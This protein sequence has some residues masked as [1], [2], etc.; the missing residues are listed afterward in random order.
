MFLLQA[1]RQ[2]SGRAKNMES[3]YAHPA[4]AAALEEFGQPRELIDSGGWI[5]ERGI[6]G[7]SACDAMGC[8]PLFAC[9]DW[10]SLQHDLNSIGQD[11]VSLVI[12]TDPFGA[13]S[14]G[15]LR[16][17]FRDWVVPFKEHFVVDLSRPLSD[18][19]CSHHRRNAEKA[20]R[21]VYVEKCKNH[22]QF[23]HDWTDLYATLIKRHEIKG[24]AAFS[25]S[26]FAK[27]FSV[28]GIVAF[29]A[30]HNEAT[31]GMALWYVQGEIGYY[32]LGAY[33][34]VGYQLRTSFALFQ[35]ALE[36]F[37][38]NLQW[39]NLGAGAGE[40][41]DSSDGLSRFKRGWSTGS[42]IAYLCG[43]I[44]DPKR[45][46]EIVQAKGIST[47]RYFPAYRAGE[48]QST[49]ESGNTIVS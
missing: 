33:N 40:K 45:Y 19:V 14:E 21:S 13:F 6:P 20:L 5:L 2:E 22:M 29:R 41:G 42:R 24:I 23:V 39:L 15:L 34:S 10:F 7:A 8:Y 12:V 11:L 9:R 47:H 48:F 36:Y 43:R 38:D 1:I 35:S 46:N 18:F 27:Q 25:A 32:H 3:G 17:T 37:R 31:V 49:R 44:F 4:Y 26:S 16:D 30:V 28:P